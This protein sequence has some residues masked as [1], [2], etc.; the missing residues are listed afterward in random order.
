MN[1]RAFL[2]WLHDRLEHEHGEN[3][4]LDYMG[5]LRSIIN[6]LPFEQDTPNTTPDIESVRLA[7]DVMTIDIGATVKLG[8]REWVL[9]AK[10]IRDHR[11]ERAQYAPTARV[12][13]TDVASPGLELPMDERARLPYDQ[14]Y[15]HIRIAMTG[16][17]IGT[18]S[19]SRAKWAKVFLE[20]NFTLDVLKVPK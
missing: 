15:A 12:W 9:E 6:A 2:S 8:G 20:G 1:D 10:P 11:D 7:T 18:V 4:Q 19:A 14:L 13:F 16:E 17:L 5:K 3:R